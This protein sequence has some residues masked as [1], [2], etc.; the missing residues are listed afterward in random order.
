MPHTNTVRVISCVGSGSGCDDDEMMMSM[1]QVS[2]YD[3]SSR[4]NPNLMGGWWIT[5]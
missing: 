5:V 4:R 2:Y 1:T 3:R